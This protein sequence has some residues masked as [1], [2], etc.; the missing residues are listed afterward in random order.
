MAWTSPF[1]DFW[2]YQKLWRQSYL[3]YLY[4]L[5]GW[6]TSTCGNFSCFLIIR[7]TLSCAAI[8]YLPPWVTPTTSLHSTYSLICINIHAHARAQQ[9]ANLHSG[10]GV[11]SIWQRWTNRGQCRAC[12]VCA[13]YRALV[14]EYISRML[15]N[16]HTYKFC[17]T[18]FHTNG[19]KI[20]HC[21]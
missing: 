20:F 14:W 15:E 1:Q 17:V 2:A 6:F 4:L 8:L 10:C 21:T 5:L 12:G 9:L 18:K 3:T 7:S 11:Y 16:F 13:L 19:Q